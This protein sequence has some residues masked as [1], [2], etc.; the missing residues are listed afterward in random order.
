MVEVAK[1]E[2]LFVM[3]SPYIGVVW[4]A[5]LL[6]KARRERD[7]LVGKNRIKPPNENN[8]HEKENSE[9]PIKENVQ[10]I[11]VIQPRQTNYPDNRSQSYL[12]HIKRIIGRLTTKCK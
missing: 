8:P 3:F 10:V 1:W 9:N 5:I 2:L 4:L 7:R 12:S 11:Q 6:V